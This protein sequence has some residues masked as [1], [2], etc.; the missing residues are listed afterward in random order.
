MQLKPASVPVEL[1]PSS[2][3]WADYRKRFEQEIEWP[4][5]C[6]RR[7]CVVRWGRVHDGNGTETFFSWHTPPGKWTTKWAGP[8]GREARMNATA[9][10][11]WNGIDLEGF[12]SQI[13]A[14]VEEVHA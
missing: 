3:W 8:R 4:D 5:E 7:G 12:A 11:I 13:A 9:S 1:S 2:D 10:R 14:W 6:A